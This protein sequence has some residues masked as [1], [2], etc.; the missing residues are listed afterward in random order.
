MIA[1]RGQRLDQGHGRRCRT[2]CEPPSRRHSL[3]LQ[4]CR[5]RRFLSNPLPLQQACQHPSSYRQ[6][7][8]AVLP[9]RHRRPQL[10][11]APPIAVVW[12]VVQPRTRPQRRCRSC[13]R[14]RHTHGG[15][16]PCLAPTRVPMPCRPGSLRTA[17]LQ[18][19]PLCRTGFDPHATPGLTVGVYRRPLLW[20]REGIQCGSCRLCL[21][22]RLVVLP[23]ATLRHGWRTRWCL[24]AAPVPLGSRGTRN[25]ALVNQRLLVK[26]AQAAAL[27]RVMAPHVVLPL[28]MPLTPTRQHVRANRLDVDSHQ[29]R[30][31][32]SVAPHNTVP[33]PLVVALGGAEGRLSL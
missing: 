26:V 5:D 7:A 12:M 29:Q 3:R 33:T 13:A 21:R 28:L 11:G 18:V 9:A 22:D 15:D 20:W 19:A 24:E 31:M 25:P 16:M 17:A 23:T 27:A 1:G 14:S 4:L 10:P 32:A 8:L 6:W 30:P 2:H